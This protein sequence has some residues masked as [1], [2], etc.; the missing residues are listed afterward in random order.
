MKIFTTQNK[1]VFSLLTFVL[2]IGLGFPSFAEANP[3]TN[4]K[5]GT[6]TATGI[7]YPTGSAICKIFNAK[8]TNEDP[9][10]TALPSQG[11]I[12][13]LENLKN[14]NISFAILQSE[15]QNQAYHTMDEF[16]DIKNRDL[17]SIFSLY[18][19]SINIF[20]RKTSDIRSFDDLKGKKINLGEKGSGSRQA[21]EKI[22]NIYNF[23]Y[24]DFAAVSEYN[25]FDQSEQLCSGVIDVAIYTVGHPSAILQKLVTTCNLRIIPLKGP[26]IEEFMRINKEYSKVIIPGSLYFGNHENVDTIAVK[27]SL[28]AM[29]DLDNKIVY[30]LVK[31]IFEN[32]ESFKKLHPALL[33]LR[34]EK[35]VKE[36]NTSPIHEGARQYYKEIGIE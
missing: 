17:R 26:K 33:S 13:N 19:E 12:S 15:I 35:M 6:G 16:S 7:Y 9:S 31:D 2:S 28:V 14:G 32:L 20:V 8:R 24:S 36:G 18:P 34:K 1:R 5:I 21:F 11:S 3:L 29:K 23:S 4:F 30:K 27:A 10:C 22:L 25:S